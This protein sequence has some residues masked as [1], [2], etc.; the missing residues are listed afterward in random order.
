MTDKPRYTIAE[1]AHR[2]GVSKQ[3]ILRWSQDG[4]INLDNVHRERS[5]GRHGFRI[6]FDAAEIERFPVSP[7]I[8]LSPEQQADLEARPLREG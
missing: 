6:V 1:A 3:T 4:T 8:Q 5:K 2:I 7:K